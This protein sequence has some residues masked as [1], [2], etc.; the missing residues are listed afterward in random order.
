MDG[1]GLSDVVNYLG[2]ESHSDIVKRMSEADVLWLTIG[3]RPGA[4]GISTGKLYEY[5]GARR[6]VLGLVPDGVA[7]EDLVRYGAAE[8]ADPEDVARYFASN[9][10]HV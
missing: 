3:K 1:A 4:D 7:R 6:P 5:F 9:R 8:L 2:Y 10:F